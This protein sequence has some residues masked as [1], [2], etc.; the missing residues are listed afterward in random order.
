VCQILSKPCRYCSLWIFLAM[1]RATYGSKSLIIALALIKN[2]L[3]VEEAALAATVEVNSQIER[4]GEMEE[5]ESTHSSRTSI[6]L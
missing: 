6:T 2:H 4:W 3:T 1:E 5:S